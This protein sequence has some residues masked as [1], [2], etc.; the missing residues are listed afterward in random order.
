MGR[1]EETPE[2]RVDVGDEPHRDS[3][4]MDG[5]PLVVVPH[6]LVGHQI[7]PKT[8]GVVAWAGS[9]T[10]TRVPGDP[11]DGRDPGDGLEQGSEGDLGGGGVAPGVGDA[12]RPFELLPEQLGQSVGPG[13]IEPVVGG[14]VD[15][16]GCSS[17]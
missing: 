10:R 12:S 2:R 16:H 1:D 13:V 4:M 6:Q 11:E 9:G 15:D 5:L 3:E 7:V 17:R 8:V 14:D